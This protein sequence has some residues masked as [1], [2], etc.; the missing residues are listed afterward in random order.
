VADKGSLGQTS[1]CFL[2]RPAI[3]RRAAS[4]NGPMPQSGKIPRL[5]GGSFVI[6]TRS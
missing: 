1:T 2:F 4:N 3:L 6:T 5:T